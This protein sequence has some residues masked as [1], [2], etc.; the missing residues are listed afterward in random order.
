MVYLIYFKIINELQK[1]IIINKCR[2]LI[3]ITN[4]CLYNLNDLLVLNV[5]LKIKIYIK[6]ISRVWISSLI[7]DE[8]IVA[9]LNFVSRI[10]A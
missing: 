10:S 3:V 1:C 6:I 7:F 9:T 2:N 5:E 8:K 4:H